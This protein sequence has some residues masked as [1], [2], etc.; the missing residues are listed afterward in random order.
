MGNPCALCTPW[1]GTGVRAPLGQES[2]L[3]RER[4]CLEVCVC[5]RVRGEAKGE[6]LCK[7]EAAP[8]IVGMTSR[9][10]VVCM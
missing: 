5:V 6:C 8:E 7:V 1:S 4:V 2:Q 10:L 9:R 3:D